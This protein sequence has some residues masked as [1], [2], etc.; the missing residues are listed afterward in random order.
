MDGSGTGLLSL[1]LCAAALAAFVDGAQASS[2]EPTVEMFT[3]PEPGAVNTHIVVEGHSA[4]WR[5]ELVSAAAEYDDIERIYPGHG[6]SQGG[7]GLL[8]KQA[9][10]LQ[11]LREAVR[12]NVVEGRLP[13]A[14]RA[15]VVATMDAK[16]PTD[17][18]ATPAGNLLELNA[19]A[20][21][22]ELAGSK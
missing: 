3:S 10:Y 18:P 4:A 2:F 11:D 21:A 16:Y 13:V 17:G 20:V 6:P 8:S 19:D 14:A 15:K 1:A 5:K 7:A 9:R 22:R 12:A